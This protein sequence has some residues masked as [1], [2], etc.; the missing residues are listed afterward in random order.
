MDSICI[1][2]SVGYVFLSNG[3]C[4]LVNSNCK[5]HSESTGLCTSCYMAFNLVNGNCVVGDDKNSAID[6]NCAAF[7]ARARASLLI[8]SSIRSVILPPYLV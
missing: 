6:P 1:R 7:A 5:T 3:F 8:R 4:G 2:C